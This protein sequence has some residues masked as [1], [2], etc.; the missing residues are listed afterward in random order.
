MILKK[1]KV[2]RVYAITKSCFN[3]G[4]GFSISQKPAY[5]HHHTQWLLGSKGSTLGA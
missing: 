4:R 3:L 1:Q 5:L 2:G